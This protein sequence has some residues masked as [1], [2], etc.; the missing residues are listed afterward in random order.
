MSKNEHEYDDIINLP[1][2]VSEKRPRMSMTD[3]AAQFSPFAALTGYNSV[4]RETERLTDRRIVLNEDEKAILNNKLQMILDFID[5]APEIT[6]V[7]FK[8][9]ERKDGG[10]YLSVSGQVKRIA[11]DTQ[12][13]VMTDGTKIPVDDIYDIESALF[14]GVEY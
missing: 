12:E 2:H 4:I 14:N 10:E 11:G 8:N 1:H 7:Y 6:V 13:L 5:T 3:R 9:D